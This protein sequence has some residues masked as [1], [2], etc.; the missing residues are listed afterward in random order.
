MAGI[1]C[2]PWSEPPTS[3]VSDNSLYWRGVEVGIQLLRGQEEGVGVS[4][5]STWGHMRKG[6]YYIKFVHLRGVGSQN[7]V[8]F[9]PLGDTISPISFVYHLGILLLCPQLYGAL[10]WHI[11]IILSLLVI[12]TDYK[13]VRRVSLS[14]SFFIKFGIKL[15]VVFQIFTIFC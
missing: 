10:I 13:Y 14:F 8:K 6:R 1:I 15:I 3:G 2:P 12:F 5:V 9:G 4:K 7:R 11:T